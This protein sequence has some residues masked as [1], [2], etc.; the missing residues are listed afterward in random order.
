MAV[1]NE[2]KSYL[3]QTLNVEELKLLYTDDASAP[4]NIKQETSPYFP[5]LKLEPASPG[6]IVKLINPQPNCPYFKKDVIIKEGFC[7]SDLKNHLNI[8]NRST[9]TFWR[10]EDPLLGSRV[11]PNLNT[12]TAGKVKLENS[13]LFRVNIDNKV[14]QVE[15]NGKIYNIG[16]SISYIVEP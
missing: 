10:W 2:N 5:Y 12:V 11:V 1:L 14:I 4:E 6:L 8:Q 7:V 15:E 16:D 9:V 13:S 3:L